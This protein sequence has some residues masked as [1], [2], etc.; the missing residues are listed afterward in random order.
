M[1]LFSKGYKM[2]LKEILNVLETLAPLAFQEEYDNAGLLYGDPG[3]EIDSAMVSLDLTPEVIREAAGKKIGLV[4]SHHPFIFGG[5]KRIIAGSPGYAILNEAVMH[6]IN[7]YAIHTNLDNSFTGLNKFVSE[8]I[9]LSDCHILAPKKGLLFKLVTFCPLDFADK[10]RNALFEAGAGHI[11]KYDSCS[12]NLEGYGTFRASDQANPFVGQK[13]VLHREPEA[14]IEVVFPGYLEDA[15]VNALK[16]AHPYEE[17][18]F[19]IYPL[20]NSFP[21]SGAG[22][23]GRLPSPVPYGDF[24]AGVKLA[25]KI[26][27]IRHSRFTGRK[28]QKVAVCTGAGSFLISEAL[29][30]GADAFLTGDLKYHDFQATGSKMLLADIGHYE[31]EQWVKE[32]ISEVLIQKFPN[33][34]VSISEKEENPVKYV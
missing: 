27:V 31:S 14:R 11:G 32:L 5:I 9:G 12:Y 26:P 25:L 4:I 30:Y 20:A 7:L 1:F 16:A 29:R 19:D 18:A 6:R 3:A 34:A 22:M 10:V 21:W 28:V 23:T 15:L 24:L 13:N 33:F 2:K 8:K 17:V